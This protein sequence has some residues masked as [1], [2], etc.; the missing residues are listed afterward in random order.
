MEAHIKIVIGSVLGDGSLSKPTTR[1][2]TSSIDISQ[3]N[4]KLPYLE[5]LHSE[6]GK[7]FKLNPI[8][9]KK[10]YNL[11]R[12]QSKPNKRLGKF[13]KTFY[14][15]NGKK[16][17]P[18]DIGELLLDPMTLAIWYMDDGTLDRRAK[19]HF[20]SMIATYCFSFQECNI[21][22][23]VLHSNFG[24]K[25]SVTKCTMRG[26]YY[27]RLYIRS[28]SME[29]FIGIIRPFIHPIFYYKIDR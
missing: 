22:K 12:F 9:P 24:I 14:D 19:Y 3:H 11:H 7:G 20:N 25:A 16:I 2:Q 6:L 26:K 8:I 15:G 13:R 5:W 27:P 17:I 4:S 29:D 18:S 28:E 10:G 1:G 21:L 23:E